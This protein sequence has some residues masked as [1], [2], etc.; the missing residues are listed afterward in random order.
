MTKKTQSPNSQKLVDSWK[1]A[2]QL[3][4]TGIFFSA[5]GAVLLITALFL[6]AHLLPLLLAGL[7]SIAVGI[8]LI[9][10]SGKAWSSD[11]VEC[12]MEFDDD[13]SLRLTALNTLLQNPT[14][15]LTGYR[16]LLLVL[17]SSRA[18]ILQLSA[19]PETQTAAEGLKEIIQQT[20]DNVW[21]NVELVE[22]ATSV[23]QIEQQCTRITS[24]FCQERISDEMA[25]TAWEYS[26]QAGKI[27]MFGRPL[28]NLPTPAIL[29][30]N[31]GKSGKE[32][33]KDKAAPAPVQFK[34][35]A[36]I[37]LVVVI[38]FTGIRLFN[39]IR[40]SSTPDTPPVVDS[41]TTE[42]PEIPEIAEVETEPAEETQVQP[43]VSTTEPSIAGP[44]NPPSDVKVTDR[45]ESSLRLT[46]R[47]PSDSSVQGY[48]ILRNGRIIARTRNVFYEDNNL[49][50]DTRYTYTI[51]SYDENRKTSGSSAPLV[52]RTN[53]DSQAPT[54][55]SGLTVTSTARGVNLRWTA[56]QDN[57]TVWG[58]DI[59]RDGRKVGNSEGT[60]Y[61]DTLSSEGTF[62]YTVRA[63]DRSRNYSDYS[64]KSSITIED[65]TPPSVPGNIATVRNIDS[66]RLTWSASTDNKGVAGYEIYRDGRK[67]GNTTSPNFTDD[68]LKMDTIYS[69][70]IRAIDIVNNYSR[71]SEAVSVKTLADNAA[72]TTPGNL[73]STA[74][75]STTVQLTWAASTDN[76]KVE[77]YEIYRDNTPVGFADSNTFTDK[78]LVQSVMYSYKV[79]AID[80][81]GNSS[82]FS[83]IIEVETEK[84]SVTI[85]YRGYKTPHI[86]YKRSNGLWTTSPGV[87][88]PNAEVSGYFK[89]TIPMGY[90][91]EIVACFNDGRGIWDSNGGANY[92]FKEGVWTYEDGKMKPGAP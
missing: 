89:I 64:N 86:H 85:Y 15:V 45:T 67:I 48:E 65:T 19:S 68:G 2:R 66:I 84:S 36:I 71:F 83:P 59:Y 9:V 7:V 76:V 42:L 3:K 28:P 60:T 61:L 23:D 63:F 26:L 14:M 20:F 70:T 77:K 39:R 74:K 73:R 1:K 37:V 21:S 58:Y 33:G 17:T 5:L 81:A 43:D 11:A 18:F 47:E 30:G 82:S 35:V 87:A 54:V 29:A 32:S 92:R 53:K 52:E 44:L 80:A 10:I 78:G 49:Q 57:V 27:I 22:P 4:H 51:R 50:A 31:A 40:L 8:G 24:E 6:H 12:S 75:T 88:M 16:N 69:Y 56:S 62:E 79:K 38:L 55:P 34:N 72:P 46:W 25:G 91:D 13:S 41:T 90:M